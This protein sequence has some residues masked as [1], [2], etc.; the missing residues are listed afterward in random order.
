MISIKSINVNSDSLIKLNTDLLVLGQK[1]GGSLSRLD[2]PL[3]DIVMSAISLESFTGKSGKIIH[4]YGDDNTKRVSV[5][6]LGEKG[7]SIL[8]VFVH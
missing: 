4:T 1:E 8:M 3:N 7:K 5:F 6:G 2:S